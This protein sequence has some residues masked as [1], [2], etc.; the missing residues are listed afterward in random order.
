[1][2]FHVK[3][4]VIAIGN[5]G[6]NDEPLVQISKVDGEVWLHP[7]LRNE[8]EAAKLFWAA[9]SASAFDQELRAEISTERAIKRAQA[10]R[11]DPRIMSQ[12]EM[13]DG[14]YEWAKGKGLSTFANTCDIAPEP[15]IYFNSK[16]TRDAWEVWQAAQRAQTQKG[17]A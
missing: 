4:P 2:K 1:M 3:E 12:S 7:S 8:S 13:L 15:L 17:Q 16:E 11:S 10:D 14:F 9:V 5:G 6:I